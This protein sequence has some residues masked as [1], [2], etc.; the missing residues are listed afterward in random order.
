MQ[1]GE[2]GAIYPRRSALSEWES[3]RKCVYFTTL[4]ITKG[5]LWDFS[6]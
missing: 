3:Q 2:Q 1:V 6:D 4:F 5:I